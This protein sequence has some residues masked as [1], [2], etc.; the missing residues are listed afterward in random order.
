MKYL[1]VIDLSLILLYKSCMQDGCTL[2]YEAAI[3]GHT[4][5]L[6]LLLSNNTDIIAASKVLQLKIFKYLIYR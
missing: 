5:T 6:A 2:A 3:N 1:F 4:E